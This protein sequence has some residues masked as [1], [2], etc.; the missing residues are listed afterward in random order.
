MS[1]RAYLEQN[2]TSVVQEALLEVVRKKPPN[3]LQF[4][5]NFILE[6]ANAK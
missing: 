1:V 6:R 3:P 5:G 2:V 4:V